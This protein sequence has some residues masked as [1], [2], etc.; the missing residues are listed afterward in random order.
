MTFI[1]SE[2]TL[3]VKLYTGSSELNWDEVIKVVPLKDVVL[4]YIQDAHALI[5][6]KRH[7]KSAE[8][9]DRILKLIV[10]KNLRLTREK[11]IGIESDVES[12]L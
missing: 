3:K 1:I 4:V 8:D 9:S 6:P 2:D 5:I 10:D 11:R 7:I 12:D